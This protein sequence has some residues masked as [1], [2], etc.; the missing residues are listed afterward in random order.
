M[1]ARLR[2]P[3]SS[4]WIV[5]LGLSAGI[6]CSDSLPAPRL[7]QHPSNSYVDVP[8]PPTAALAETVPAGPDR[9]DVVW[10]DGDWSFRGKGYVWRRGGWVVP[11]PGA[12]YAPSQIR[13]LTDGRV[14]FAP[15]TWYDANGEPAPNPIKIA[16][17][18]TP[19]NEV[20]AEYLTGR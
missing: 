4:L 7:T 15:G 10:I 1:F 11:P 17:A 14:L 16:P 3:Q 18:S 5:S 12:R 19:P 13:Y 6:G 20:T 9:S 2:I 8:Y